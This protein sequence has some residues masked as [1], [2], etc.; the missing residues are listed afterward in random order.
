MAHPLPYTSNIAEV[1]MISHGHVLELDARR[2][3]V[4]RVVDVGYRRSAVVLDVFRVGELCLDQ[5]VPIEEG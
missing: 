3:V 4:S 2:A 5:A 1:V